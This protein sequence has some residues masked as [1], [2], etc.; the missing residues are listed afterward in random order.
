V[1]DNKK[2]PAIEVIEQLGVELEIGGHVWL[3][4]GVGGKVFF[5]VFDGHGSLRPL[6]RRDIREL[7]GYMIREVEKSE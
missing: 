1:A 5:L 3:E 2:T 4:R 6:T 7:A